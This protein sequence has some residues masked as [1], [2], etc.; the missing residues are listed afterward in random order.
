MI[1]KPLDTTDYLFI[2][3]WKAYSILM[4]PHQESKL[5]KNSEVFVCSFM[6]LSFMPKAVFDRMDIW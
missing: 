3:Q 6:T 1:M 2:Y 4:V 5:M